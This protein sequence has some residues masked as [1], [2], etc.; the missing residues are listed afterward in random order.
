MNF[1][2]AARTLVG[3]AGGKAR[4]GRAV[5]SSAAARSALRCRFKGASMGGFMERGLNIPNRE[6]TETVITM[7]IQKLR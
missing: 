3:A 5:S 4:A 1:V 7:S 6:D 2:I